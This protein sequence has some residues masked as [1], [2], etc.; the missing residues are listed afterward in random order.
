LLL[1]LLLLLLILLMSIQCLYHKTVR[2]YHKD[3]DKQTLKSLHTSA[4]RKLHQATV[5]GHVPQALLMANKQ[6]RLIVAIAYNK[7]ATFLLTTPIIMLTSNVHSNCMRRYALLGT[8][9][10]FQFNSSHTC[11]HIFSHDHM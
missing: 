5:I 6:F 2:S 7:K 1:L 8:E 11:S 10:N 9:I 3:T 4:I